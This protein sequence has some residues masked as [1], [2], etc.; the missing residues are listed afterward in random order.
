MDCL[1][2]GEGSGAFICL[3]KI[4]QS[5]GGFEIRIKTVVFIKACAC[6][7]LRSFS[8]IQRRNLGEQIQGEI[9]LDEAE[10]N[11]QN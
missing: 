3:N 11:S 8:L 5:G 7:L 1:F 10:E 6:S 4:Q 9:A 2:I